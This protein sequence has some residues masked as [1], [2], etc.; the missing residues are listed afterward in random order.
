MERIYLPSQRYPLLTVS[1]L[2]R[3]VRRVDG[4]IWP[5]NFNA[6]ASYKDAIRIFQSAPPEDGTPKLWWD[7]A[8]S[9]WHKHLYAV[10]TGVSEFKWGGFQDCE[11]TF[12][13]IGQSAGEWLQ[14]HGRIFPYIPKI[15][16]VELSTAEALRKSIPNGVTPMSPNLSTPPIAMMHPDEG[17]PYTDEAEKKWR[18]SFDSNMVIVMHPNGRPVCFRYREWVASDVV[19]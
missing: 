17:G 1:E 10:I 5:H 2:A 4:Q 11:H 13:V 9:N 6:A 8:P 3:I 16:I 19:L 14:Q 7:E 15:S 12:S 18:S